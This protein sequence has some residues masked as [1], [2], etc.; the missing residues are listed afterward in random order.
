MCKACSK[1]DF[2]LIE[3]CINDVKKK[4][5]LKETYISGTCEKVKKKVKEDTDVVITA[6]EKR[7]QRIKE[8]IDHEKECLT[9][10]MNQRHEMN[11]K[12]I[13]NLKEA[14]EFDILS[15]S[16]TVEEITTGPL[17]SE[18]MK[19][20]LEES[21]S[22]SSDDENAFRFDVFRF[23]PSSDAVKLGWLSQHSLDF[24]GISMDYS[25]LEGDGKGKSGKFKYSFIVGAWQGQCS[26]GCSGVVILDEKF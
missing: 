10:K 17:N 24:P 14:K 13:N 22:K 4:I 11:Q 6:I 5:H 26:A 12:V 2:K 20:L 21:C 25:N 3:G 9:H 1:H 16:K 7:A 15:D 19:F 18:H 8:Q 23:N